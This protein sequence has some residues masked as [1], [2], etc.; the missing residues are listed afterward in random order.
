MTTEFNLRYTE[1]GED[2]LKMLIADKGKKV[3]LKAVV[4]ALKMMGAN[5]KHPSL[6]THK[7]DEMEGPNGEEVFES[8]AQNKTPGAYRIF[9]HYGPEKKMITILSITPHP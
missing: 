3:A 9:W 2:D 1:N 5:L 4:K 7:Y 6:H 8:Y